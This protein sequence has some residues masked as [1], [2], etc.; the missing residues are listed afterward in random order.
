L[1]SRVRSW[2]FLLLVLA[3]GLIWAASGLT[4]RALGTYGYY[5]D[6]EQDTGNTITADTLDPRT[7]LAASEDGTDEIDLTWTA[8]ADAYATGYDIYRCQGVA[9]NPTT[10]LVALTEAAA[11]CV[12]PG[13]S[14]CAYTDGGLSANT[15]YCYKVRT[16]YLNWDSP[17]TSTACAT[18]ES[19]AVA[20]TLLLHNNNTMS[21]VAGT[22]GVVSIAAADPDASYIWSYTPAVG[23]TIQD[24]DYT[25]VIVQGSRP[26]DNDGA[27]V[28]IKV[29]Y[30]TDC[31]A[32]TALV[33][34]NVT[35]PKVGDDKGISFTLNPSAAHT[36]AA[37][38][39]LCLQ[40]INTAS[41]SS[42]ARDVEIRT[43]D[44]SST[45]VAGKSSLSVTIT[46]P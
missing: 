41:P 28:T 5:F 25:L 32:M 18:T 31:S 26:T 24:L 21:A 33:T 10:L 38:E 16:T 15:Q 12:T 20:T 36:F 17:F 9:C 42:T 45:G 35:M 14:S 43:D 40:I 3:V 19:A 39:K 29:G 46:G 4:G 11:A 27:S 6:T 34:S 30:G 1:R 8:S 37:G 44:Q 22:T 23:S 7:N 2:S 13:D